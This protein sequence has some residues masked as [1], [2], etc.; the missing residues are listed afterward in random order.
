MKLV[1]LSEYL[2]VMK[3]M[4]GFNFFFNIYKRGPSSMELLKI[5][6]HL[7]DRGLIEKDRSGYSLKKDGKLT[8]DDFIHSK[9][10]NKQFFGIID[11]VVNEYGKLDTEKLLAKIYKMNVKPIHSTKEINIGNEV[12]CSEK[13]PG[14]R[15]LMRLDKDCVQKELD[16]SPEWIETI[17]ILLNPSFSR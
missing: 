16:V 7:V 2:M 13:K 10:E 14:K 3:N 15:L 6:D 12:K 1:F 17:N 5:L 9:S 4:K 11:E 8:I